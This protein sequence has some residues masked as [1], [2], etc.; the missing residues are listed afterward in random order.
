MIDKRRRLNQLHQDLSLVA[1][2]VPAETHA[3][4]NT[5]RYYNALLDEALHQNIGNN[6]FAIVG[7]AT[8]QT[9]YYDLL[10][11]AGQL[12]AILEDAEASTEL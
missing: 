2:S 11:M 7:A 12:K 6:S 3:T 10:I 1:A 9:T 4:E 5:R 8:D